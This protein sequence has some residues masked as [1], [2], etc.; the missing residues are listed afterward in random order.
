ML[1]QNGDYD[2]EACLLAAF[3][4]TAP[5]IPLQHP[6]RSIGQAARRL[7]LQASLLFEEVRGRLPFHDTLRDVVKRMR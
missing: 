1:R 6:S 3:D 2:I 4:P 5:E 7:D